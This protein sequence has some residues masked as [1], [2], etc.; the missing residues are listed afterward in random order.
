MITE[1]KGVLIPTT[2]HEAQSHASYPIPDHILLNLELWREKIHA[3]D[4]TTWKEEERKERKIL[5]YSRRHFL[6]FLSAFLCAAADGNYNSMM[7][8]KIS[9]IAC[10]VYCKTITEGGRNF[11][12]SK[13]HALMH[14]TMYKYGFAGSL[15]RK[16]LYSLT[17]RPSKS[18]GSHVSHIQKTCARDKR[19]RYRWGGSVSLQWHLQLRKTE[20][21]LESGPLIYGI[22]A[23][24]LTPNNGDAKSLSEILWIK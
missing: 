19:C 11:S 14:I 12:S 9:W 1:S 17:F 6:V 8:W 4:G 3:P 16:F 13:L 15:S 24:Q 23:T 5:S 7:H 2:Q 10:V 21:I 20:E 18:G 22:D